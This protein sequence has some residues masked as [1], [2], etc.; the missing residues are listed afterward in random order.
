MIRERTRWTAVYVAT[1]RSKRTAVLYGQYTQPQ[2]GGSFNL[3]SCMMKNFPF[4]L[5]SW[6]SRFLQL[7]C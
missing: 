2:I 6:N 5:N 4:Y 1:K 3:P 7:F